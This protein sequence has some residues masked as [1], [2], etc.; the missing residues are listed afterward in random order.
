MS[1]KGKLDIRFLKCCKEEDAY[2]NWRECNIIKRETKVL[3]PYY[4]L[5][6]EPRLGKVQIEG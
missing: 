2:L 5:L 4:P 6:P 3:K 1:V